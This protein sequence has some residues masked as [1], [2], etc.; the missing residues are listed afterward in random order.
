MNCSA[1]E[2]TELSSQILGKGN[3]LRFQARGNS[4]F[5]A[6]KHADILT[7]EPVRDKELQWLDILFFKAADRHIV[8][9]RLVKKIFQD[10]EL[11]LV[12]RGDYLWSNDEKILFKDVLGRVKSIE[13]NKRIINLGSGIG[14]LRN[15]FFALVSV[16]II[17]LRQIAGNSLR[18]IQGLKT[19][20]RLAKRLIKKEIVYQYQSL[21]SCGSYLLARVGDKI[22]GRAKIDSFTKEHYLSS[23]WWIS[24]MWV[25]W[26][27][28]G[29]GIAE[30]LTRMLFDFAGDQ[31][32]SNI[33]LLVFKNNQ[34]AINLYKKTGFKQFSDHNIDQELKR[35]AEKTK[36]Q[37]IAMIRYL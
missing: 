26:H 16:L 12:T 22:I 15:L 34:A 2:F 33:K 37:S 25:D 7:V 11:I 4:M 31:G 24:G 29:V 17:K 1:I 8:A 19:Y 18:L 21:D 36:R 14:R 13:R 27:Y 35:Q 9:H 30:R 3:C 28:R 6:I 5:P 23:G 10:D 20:R 32:V